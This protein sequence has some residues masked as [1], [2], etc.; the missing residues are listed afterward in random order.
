MKPI[1][2]NHLLCLLAAVGVVFLGGC[3]KSESSGKKSS[4]TF[5][6]DQEFN[7]TFEAEATT[8]NIFFTADGIWMVQDENG[9]EA[10]KRWYSVTPTHGAGGE[11]FVELSIPENTDMDK[12]RTAVFSI[13]CG[14]DKQL[15]TILQ[16]SRNAAESKHVY[17]ADE[18][19]KSYCVE[20]FDTDGDGRISKEE[21]AAITEIDCQEREITSL[22]GIK[23]MTALTTLNC[24][25]NSI[26]GILDLSG[27]KNLKTVNADHNF[28][29]R[30]D[31]SGCSALETLV[32]NDNYGYNEQSKM[33]FTLAE[34]DLTGCAALKKVSLQDNAITTL[35]LK[36]SPELEEINMSMN[37]L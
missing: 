5:S 22:E 3:K 19:F 7:L 20:N 28:Y 21:A 31:L 2:K 4:L 30:L 32:A 14:A 6:Q 11:T 34:V 12:D 9:L 15:F 8:Q 17:F 10:D 33:V 13:I 18:K 23:Y 27:L 37:Q 16:Y 1:M 35:S 26:E 36:D 24:R 25:Y 29:S